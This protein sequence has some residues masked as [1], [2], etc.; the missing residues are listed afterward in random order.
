MSSAIPVVGAVGRIAALAA[1]A[2]AAEI[3]TP[4]LA[5]EV[6]SP[7]TRP[8]PELGLHAGDLPSLTQRSLDRIR[9][10]QLGHVRVDVR[11]EDE[12]WRDSLSAA[13]GLVRRIGCRL[14]LGVRWTGSLD[15]GQL[16]ALRDSLPDDGLV[17]RLLVLGPGNKM[18]TFRELHLVRDHVRR[19]LPTAEVFA[20]AGDHFVTLDRGWDEVGEADGVSFTIRPR[21]TPQMTCPCSRAWTGRPPRSGRRSRRVAAYRSPSARSPWNPAAPTTRRIRARRPC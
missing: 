1:Y 5:V 4:H 3:E 14:E 2:T 17:R 20:A 6:G 21:L 12:G 7:T 16:G 10:L 19:R 9:S 13:A 18:A 8:V 11:L 15:Q